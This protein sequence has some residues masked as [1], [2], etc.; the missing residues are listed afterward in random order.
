LHA[1]I[2]MLIGLMLA[3]PSAHALEVQVRYLGYVETYSVAPGEALTDVWR[4]V[5]VA[6]ERRATRR[7]DVTIEVSATAQDETVE[8]TVSVMDA[9]A[10]GERLV[11]R[12]T[13]R[14]T[15]DDPVGTFW[16]GQQVPLV[17]TEEDG[18]L[19]VRHLTK[20]TIEIK[21]GPDPSGWLVD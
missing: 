11:A 8:V 15:D 19:S 14:L 1:E 21:V 7:A 16:M 20:P 3:L 9:R 12:P 4:Q 13:L 5:P 6:G 10:G 17:D 2:T 18:V